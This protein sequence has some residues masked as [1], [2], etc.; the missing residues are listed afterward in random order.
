MSFE[1]LGIVFVIAVFCA[2][3]AVAIRYIARKPFTVANAVLI[4]IVCAVVTHFIMLVVLQT[5]LILPR[6]ANRMLTIDE[7]R[8]AIRWREAWQGYRATIQGI[9]PAFTSFMILANYLILRVGKLLTGSSGKAIK[10]T[11]IYQQE[12]DNN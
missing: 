11:I 3:P 6:P 8:K 2:L 9:L 7:M 10:T 5:E 4:A 1:L 12:S